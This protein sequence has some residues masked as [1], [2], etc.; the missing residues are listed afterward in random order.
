MAEVD[1]TLIMAVLQRMQADVA[2]IKR[3]IHRLEVRQSVIEGHM[4]SFLV[5]LQIIREEVDEVRADVRQIKHRLDLVDA[6]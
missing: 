6:E 4:S 1:G 5:S 3:D 2:E